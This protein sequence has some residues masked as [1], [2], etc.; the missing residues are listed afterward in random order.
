MIGK[1]IKALRKQSGITQKK[2]A[3]SMG[4]THQSISDWE[5]GKKKPTVESLKKLEELLLNDVLNWFVRIKKPY[6]T[7]FKDSY[8]YVYN[9]DDRIN[10]LNWNL[11]KPYL[12]DQSEELINFLYSLI[13]QP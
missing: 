9:H 5:L 13:E 8:F 7:H 12:K 1:K 4:I 3:E 2:L 6:Y 10:I 11:E